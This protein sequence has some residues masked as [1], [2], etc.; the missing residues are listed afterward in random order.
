VNSARTDTAYSEKLM[1]IKAGKY[2]L[3]LAGFCCLEST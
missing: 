3:C 2:I 1:H